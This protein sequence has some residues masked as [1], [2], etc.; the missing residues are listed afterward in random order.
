VSLKESGGYD[1]KRILCSLT[2]IG[3]L[4]ACGAGNTPSDGGNA[5]SI[6]VTCVPIVLTPGQ[7]GN[8]TASAKDQSG[9]ALSSQ[10]V[11]SFTSSDPSKVTVSSTGQIAGVATGAAEITAS[12][13]GKTSNVARIIVEAVGS[14]TCGAFVISKDANNAFFNGTTSDPLRTSTIIGTL[15][16]SKDLITLNCSSTG[17][18]S[19]TTVVRQV[20]IQVTASGAINAGQSYS[21]Q[22]EYLITDITTPCSTFGCPTLQWKNTPS[23]SD[24]KVESINGKTYRVT[25][26]NVL[27]TP[28]SPAKGNVRISG[29][30]TSTLVDPA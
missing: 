29:D 22:I 6:I 28:V 16:A 27:L 4:T 7:L 1:M 3:L 5:S 10:P 13:G 23:P 11:F 15:N 21:A 26:S 8:C 2:L 17:T 20:M 9:N 19:G 24:V 18:Y 12:G 14:N 30:V 25:Y